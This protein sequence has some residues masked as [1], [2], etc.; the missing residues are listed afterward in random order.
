LYEIESGQKTRCA[1]FGAAQNA[2]S[3]RVARRGQHDLPLAGVA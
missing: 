1:S 3:P 2:Q